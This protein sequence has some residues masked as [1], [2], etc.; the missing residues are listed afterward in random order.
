VCLDGKVILYR[1]GNKSS[2]VNTFAYRQLLAEDT[3]EV[4]ATLHEQAGLL[5]R[6][7]SEIDSALAS[8]RVEEK[9]SSDHRKEIESQVLSPSLLH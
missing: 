4:I 1:N 2:E 6:E 7:M 9:K 3:K 5:R 8:L